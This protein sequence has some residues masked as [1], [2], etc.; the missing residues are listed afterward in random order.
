MEISVIR[1]IGNNYITKLITSN[2]KMQ[3]YV[4]W[5]YDNI[6]MRLKPTESVGLS[7]SRRS[8]IYYRIEG[9]LYGD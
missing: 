6:I 4:P 2:N 7:I 5:I 8:V 9:E 1:D 3:Y